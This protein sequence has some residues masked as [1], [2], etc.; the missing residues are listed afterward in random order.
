MPAIFE[1]NEIKARKRHKC[2]E[3][4]RDINPGD[5]YEYCSGL[6]DGRWGHYKTCETCADIRESVSATICTNS[7]ELYESYEYLVGQEVAD[8]VFGKRR[9]TQ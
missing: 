9:E 3:C 6:W 8:R 5:T 2:C 1:S 4:G 7:G